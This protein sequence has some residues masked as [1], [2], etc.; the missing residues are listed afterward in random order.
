MV[1]DLHLRCFTVP[2]LCIL[3]NSRRTMGEMAVKRFDVCDFSLMEQRNRQSCDVCD[4]S[5]AATRC[6]PWPRTATPLIVSCASISSSASGKFKISS[7]APLRPVPAAVLQRSH[8]Y[9]RVASNSTGETRR[10]RSIVAGKA[11]HYPPGIEI[12]ITESGK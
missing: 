9:Y 11:Y 4:S 7:V 6:G 10:R 1:S 8:V 3:L 5:T 12:G 2:S